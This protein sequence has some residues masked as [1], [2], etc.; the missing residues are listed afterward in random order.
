MTITKALVPTGKQV[1]WE[2]SDKGSRNS[3]LCVC[4]E[5]MV[6]MCRKTSRE[7]IV[8]WV[9]IVDKHTRIVIRIQVHITCWCWHCVLLTCICC[10]SLYPPCHLQ[11]PFLLVC[12]HRKHFIKHN[13]IIFCFKKS[14]C[15]AEVLRKRTHAPFQEILAFEYSQTIHVTAIEHYIAAILVDPLKPTFFLNCM[16]AYLKLSK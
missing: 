2:T 1:R 8:I 11:H 14:P 7:Y 3:Y 6:C 5:R 13:T 12:C 4:I 15:T 9:R 16:A 10:W